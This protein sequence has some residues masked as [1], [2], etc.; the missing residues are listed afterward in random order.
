MNSDKL[1]SIVGHS[2]VP[3][4]IEPVDGARIEIFRLPG[5]K[6]STF[7]SNPQLANVLSWHHDL[8]ILFL[9]GNDINDYCIPSEIARNI[10]NLV[11][12]I[13]H[14]CA[15]HISLVLI[16][17]RNP[18]PGNRFNVTAKNYNRIANNIN[19]RLKRKL[20]NKTYVNFLSI[21]AKPFR[22]GVTDGIHFDAE[23]RIQLKQKF[24]NTIKHF[25]DNN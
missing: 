23:S 3:H 2:L 6:V 11:E 17:H 19:K 25:I 18:P 4:T 16:E 13:H 20:K 14:N 15:S 5:A 21:G 10:E 12:I 7:N 24:R 8:T 22:Q 1:V 9:G